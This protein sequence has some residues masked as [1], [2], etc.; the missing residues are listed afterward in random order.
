MIIFQIKNETDNLESS[1]EVT[2]T[3]TD[4][5]D[6]DVVKEELNISADEHTDIIEDINEE[7]D[8]L[9]LDISQV[10]SKTSDSQVKE[11]INQ[12]FDNV[13]FKSKDFQNLI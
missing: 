2:D 7:Q 4:T 10:S 11:E 8:N 12:D 9:N 3:R 5:L 13:G 6:T 1:F